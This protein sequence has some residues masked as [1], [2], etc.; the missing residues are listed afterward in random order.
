MY[1]DCLY[2]DAIQQYLEDT[3]PIVSDGGKK[4]AD[5]SR[6]PHESHRK[7]LYHVDFL[8]CAEWIT[9]VVTDTSLSQF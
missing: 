2:S 4:S 7:T 5:S 8:T 6:K 9:A 3:D 1:H